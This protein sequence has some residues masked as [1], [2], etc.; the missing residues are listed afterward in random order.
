M[1]IAL[2]KFLRPEKKFFTEEAL[3]V[4]IARDVQSARRYYN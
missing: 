2:H 4:Q 1:E 3:K